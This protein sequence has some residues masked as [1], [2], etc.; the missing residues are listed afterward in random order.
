MPICSLCVYALTWAPCAAK[1]YGLGGRKPLGLGGFDVL[2]FFFSFWA[3]KWTLSSENREGRGRAWC[4][5]EGA[6]E[7]RAAGRSLFSQLCAGEPS[8][9]LTALM[10]T[11]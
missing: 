6:E 9:E 8:L 10:D 5:H 11:S 2:S 4:P 3:E 1:T 7:C